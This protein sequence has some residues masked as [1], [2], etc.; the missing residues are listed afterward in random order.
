MRKLITLL[1]ILALAVPMAAT[2]DVDF[3][4]MTDQ[5]LKDMIQSCSE[6]LQQRQTTPE[7]WV[8]I[9]EYDGIKIYQTGEAK[10]FLGFLDI[11]VAV[12]NDTDRDILITADDALCN[13]WDVYSS[14]CSA[15]KHTKNR[16]EISFHTTDAFVK[17]I[18]QITSLQF[19]WDVIDT[20]EKA[21]SIYEQE[22]P[23]EHRFW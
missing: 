19:R 10:I 3:A 20:T 11:P 16:G 6:E 21:V 2:A 12:F 23:E 5:Q 15:K 14:G 9:F 1:L 17:S 7:G 18:D 22:E 4:S 13:G 8:L